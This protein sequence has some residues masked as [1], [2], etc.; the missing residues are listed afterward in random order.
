ML[1]LATLAVALVISAPALACWDEARPR[2]RYAAY[3]YAPSYSY[4]SYGYYPG[5]Y[6]GYGYGGYYGYGI[7]RGI[8]RRAYWR[9][10]VGDRVGRGYVAHRAGM[11]IGRVD[12]IGRG[13]FRG[14]IGGGRGGRR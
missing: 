1:K 10:R 5:Y 4:A 11:G 2:A 12:G 9:N 3:G 14:G 6:G 7:G 13:G 8:V